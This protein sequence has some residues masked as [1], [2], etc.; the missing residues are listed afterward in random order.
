MDV[1]DSDL[2]Q[3]VS[4]RI[5]SDD[6]KNLAASHYW[7][8]LNYATYGAEEITSALQSLLSFSTSMASKC[9]AFEGSFSTFLGTNHSVFCNSGSSADL[10]A[11]SSLVKSPDYD[12]QV[13]DSVL[14]P[15]ITWPTQIWSIKQA[16]LIPVLY[17][18]CP[19]TFNPDLS[20]VPADVLKHCKAVFCTHI[21]GTS[22]DITELLQ[23]CDDNDLI[24]LEDTCES[25]GATYQGQKLGTFGT[26]GTYSCFFSH[27]ITTMEG[28]LCTTNDEDLFLQMS[29][30]R[31]HGWTRSVTSNYLPKFLSKRSIDLAEY[32]HIDNRY[33]F[34]DE[35]YNLRPTEIS[36]SF[37]LQQ[38]KK[39]PGY[40]S[41][42]RELS[43]Y[44]YSKVS[45]FNCLDGP[46]LVE[47]L[48]PSFMALP[49]T[50]NNSSFTSS[51]AIS[52][53]ESRGIETR[54]LIAGN[55]LQHPVSK[56]F[57]LASAH[58]LHGANH[59][60]ERSFYV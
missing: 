14:V 53:L 5:N 52:Y 34:I 44:F 59:H 45:S 42:R 22:C 40:V 32:E 9:R 55:I 60:H 27:H 13:G 49:L 8:P 18:C 20:L 12:L 57:N 56:R 39:L 26:V 29:I 25:L 30:L 21:L 2:L 6:R 3:L 23:I 31:A 15:A 38:L 7:Y 16:G 33:L 10:L 50:I 24:L 48:N 37:G 17:D 54:P 46:K 43:S 19:K 58:P 1:L 11:I 36:A 51:H 4:S 28:G 41:R 47:H 35:G